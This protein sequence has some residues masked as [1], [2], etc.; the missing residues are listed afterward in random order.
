MT[1]TADSK[2]E[3]NWTLNQWMLFHKALILRYPMATTFI[4]KADGSASFTNPAVAPIYNQYWITMSKNNDSVALREMKSGDDKQIQKELQYFGGFKDTATYYDFVT[5]YLNPIFNIKSAAYGIG[6]L[7]FELF[8][9]L[10]TVVIVA[11][12]FVAFVGGAYVYNSVRNAG[13][14]RY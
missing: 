4:K 6:D 3:F 13:L 2:P 7:S 5:R 8:G 14:R 12:V 9:G 10:K 1:I 11:A